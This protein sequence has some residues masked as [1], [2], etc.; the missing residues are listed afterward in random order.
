[1]LVFLHATRFKSG[2]RLQR[3]TTHWGGCLRLIATR[4]RRNN[5][6][7]LTLKS[8]AIAIPSRQGRSLQIRVA[9]PISAPQGAF[10]MQKNLII[11]SHFAKKQ[12]KAV[13]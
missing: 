10:L 9:P 7:R 12:S 5:V 11:L 8:V 3:T 6:T 13:D 2:W 4:H 1:M